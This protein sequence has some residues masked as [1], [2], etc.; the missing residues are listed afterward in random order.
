MTNIS[1][2]TAIEGGQ[3]QDKGKHLK[4]KYILSIISEKCMLS[5]I[6]LKYQN[7]IESKTET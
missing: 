7:V 6:M 1:T 5:I 2:V 4:R 3:D